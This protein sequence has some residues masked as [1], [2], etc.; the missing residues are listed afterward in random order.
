MN[1]STATGTTEIIARA[2]LRRDGHLLVVRQRGK[3][4]VFLPGGHVDPGERVEAALIREITEELGA[5]A[6]VEGFLGAV[7]H[8]YTEDGRTHHEI[9]LVF[10]VDVDGDRLVSQEEHLE[11]LWV[12]I[13]DLVDTDLRPGRLKEGVLADLN[14]PALGQSPS[15]WAWAE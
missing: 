1:T 7:E 9:N 5:A 3:K 10:A 11:F 15:W 14:H 8:G 2:V 12:P 4:W 6:T 13:D